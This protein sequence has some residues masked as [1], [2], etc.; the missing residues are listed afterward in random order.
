[1]LR[2]SY[3]PKE[4]FWL[5]FLLLFTIIVDGIVLYSLLLRPLLT[6]SLLMIGYGCVFIG[7]NNA[8]TS[9]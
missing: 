6:I 3:T 2:P 8:A 4:K 5:A 7:L 1:M 9:K